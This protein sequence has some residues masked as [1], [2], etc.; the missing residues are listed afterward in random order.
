MSTKTFL[1]NGQLHNYTL[2]F[3]VAAACNLAA[4]IWIL[5]MINEKRDLKEFRKR[6]HMKEDLEMQRK[7][8]AVCDKQQLFNEN[9]HI[10]PLKLLFNF[11]N[12][13]DMIKTCCK[14]RPN[15]AR[16][17]IWLLFLSMICYLMAHMGANVFQFPFV[18]EVYPWSFLTYSDATAI[19]NVIQSLFTLLLAPILIK[20]KTINQMIYISLKL[21][22][23]NQMREKF[24]DIIESKEK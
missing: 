4:F 22:S 20:V 6:F 8:Q 1:K 15:K 5:L 24:I 13:K 18:E 9:K 17:Q 16:L 2:V 14:P 11:E 23:I 7:G 21:L 10:H 19:G 12:I 3:L